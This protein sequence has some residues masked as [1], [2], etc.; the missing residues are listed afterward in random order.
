VCVHTIYL[1]S[2]KS[3]NDLK[4]D[5][6]YTT[7]HEWIDFHNIEA[8]IGITNLRVTGVRQIKKID[9]V[10][11]YGFKKKGEVLANIQFDSRR[12]QVRMP[13]DG[14]IISINDTNLLVSQNLLLSKPETEGWLVKI[15]ISQP[16]QKKGLIPCE[17]YDPA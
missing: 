12:V 10:R 14:N 7:S 16:C 11:V 13:V 4:R 2:M 9:F 8:F 17:Q 3:A 6:Y 15:L 1:Y 5:L